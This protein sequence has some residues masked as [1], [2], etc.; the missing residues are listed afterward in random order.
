MAVAVVSVLAEQRTRPARTPW[1]PWALTA[2]AA[3]SSIVLNFGHPY[4]PLDPPPAG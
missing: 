4:I 2:L 1:Y 3:G